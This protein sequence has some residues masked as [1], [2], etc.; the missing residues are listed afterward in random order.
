MEE[1]G[2]REGCPELASHRVLSI[3]WQVWRAWPEDIPADSVSGS[4]G[5]RVWRRISGGDQVTRCGLSTESG[6]G[7]GW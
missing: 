5:C 2:A 4:R 7:G 3:E 6:F 1:A